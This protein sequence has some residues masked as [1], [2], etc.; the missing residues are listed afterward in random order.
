[1]ARNYDP[2][3]VQRFLQ[4]TRGELADLFNVIDGTI[5]NW[6]SRGLQ[7]V[8][9]QRPQIFSGHEV[10]RFL[11][12]RQF[13][14]RSE[15]KDGRLYCINCFRYRFLKLNSIQHQPDSLRG[16]QLRGDCTVCDSPISIYATNRQLADIYRVAANNAQD[17]SADHDDPVS[18]DIVGLTTHI[19]PETNKSNLRIIFGF[20]TYL[21]EHEGFDLRTVDEYLRSL[22][23]MSFVAWYKSFKEYKLD[24]P[25][26]VK[27][28][29]RAIG[30]DSEKKLLALTTI[31][32]S[33]NHCERF[34]EWLSRQENSRLPPDLPG[35]F[36]LSLREKR[37]ASDAVKGTEF[38]FEQALQIL[39][40]MLPSSSVEIRNRAIVALFIMTG[41]RAKALTTLR[42]KHVNTDTFWVFQIPPEVQTKANKNIRSYCLPIS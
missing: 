33:L 20:Q 22:A 21:L 35:Y 28:A 31:D 10:R 8:D 27:E 26:A 17:S 18:S 30:P 29:F 25:H 1:M 23:K 2:S 32:R 36:R 14:D 7:P 5:T 41:I 12:Q 34:F 4:Y 13:G 40:T 38:S 3:K 37:I 42:G 24:D 16:N 39:E 15:P 9:D 19:F 11:T 6:H